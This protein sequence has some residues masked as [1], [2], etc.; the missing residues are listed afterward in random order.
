MGILKILFLYQL[1]EIMRGAKSHPLQG[2]QRH[3]LFYIQNFV[4]VDYRMFNVV[5]L[6]G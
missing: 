6:N 4:W 2:E 3:L 5:V 1:V